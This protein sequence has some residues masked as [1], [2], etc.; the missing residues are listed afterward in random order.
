MNIWRS[1]ILVGLM[2]VILIGSATADQNTDSGLY[3]SGS[4]GRNW[5]QSGL[6]EESTTIFKVA[7]GWQFNPN[8]SVE[9]GYSDFG[10]Y[11]GPTPAYTDFDLTGVSA[12]LI[13]QLPISSSTAL[14]GRLGQIWWEADSSFF[15]FNRSGG[16][17]QTGT[18]NF[19]ESD[20]VLGLGVSFEMTQEV[21]LELEYNHY[22]FGFGN[23][24][25]FNNDSAALVFSIK[26][27]L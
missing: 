10:K 24:P 25:N 21:E 4:L 1:A 6:P 19:S 26:Y 15:F 5:I 23:Q 20:I 27:E 9:L 16:S 18:L 3:L 14:F 11:P 13:A 2:S 12:A 22:D 17:N 8:I 7:A